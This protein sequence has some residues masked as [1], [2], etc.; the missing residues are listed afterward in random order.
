MKYF[1]PPMA[2]AGLTGF[3]IAV[4]GGRAVAHPGHAVE[5]LPAT[6]PAHWIAQP[7]HGVYWV[8]V[9]V[10]AAVLARLIRY[11]LRRVDQGAP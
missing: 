11:G 1:R 9:V 4:I 7:E 2:T 6:N 5:V 10:G 8:M 3:S